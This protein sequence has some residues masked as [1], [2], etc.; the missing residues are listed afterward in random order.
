MNKA[1]TGIVAPKWM[2]WQQDVTELRALN[3]KTMEVSCQI[4]RDL[5]MPGPWPGISLPR[6]TRDDE[7]ADVAKLAAELVDAALP[8]NVDDTW[9]ATAYRLARAYGAILKQMP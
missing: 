1:D 6:S 4:A 3:E 2:R 9:G 5:V 7:D 8:G